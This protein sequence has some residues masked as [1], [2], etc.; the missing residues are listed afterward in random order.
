MCFARIFYILLRNVLNKFGHSVLFRESRIITNRCFWAFSLEI[1][2][3]LCY[4]I[5]TDSGILVV[6]CFVVDHRGLASHFLTVGI[7]CLLNS[8]ELDVVVCISTSS[9][10]PASASA[11]H[12]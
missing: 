7:T 10:G 6:I 3:N 8:I 1:K 9:T 2:L 11:P 12:L 5:V 4:L